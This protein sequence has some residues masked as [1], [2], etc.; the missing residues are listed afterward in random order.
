MERVGDLFRHEGLR[1]AQLAEVDGHED[2]VHMGHLRVQLLGHGLQAVH[3]LA[4]ATQGGRLP[5]K[6]NVCHCSPFGDDNKRVIT[7]PKMT[8]EE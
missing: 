2:R 5:K 8:T 7:F 6:T 1:Q 4:E 3:Q